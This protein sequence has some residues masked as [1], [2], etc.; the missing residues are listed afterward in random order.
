M[1]GTFRAVTP[2][3]RTR[4]QDLSRQTLAGICAAYD[5]TF[6]LSFTEIS[7]FV[8][9]DP[10][11][12]TETLPAIRRA[13]GET[14]VV[15]VPVRM[16]SEDFS[17][18]QK[19]IPGFYFRLGTGNKAKGIT[20]DIHTPDFDVDEECLPVGVKAMAN[21]LVDFLERHAA[22]SWIK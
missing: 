8:Y 5:A 13:I 2:E 7:T 17:Y 1:Q 6:D 14:N 21:V 15:E 22:E 3:M 4:V 12:V 9:N 16:G 20:A 19:I 18:F 11:L 10:K